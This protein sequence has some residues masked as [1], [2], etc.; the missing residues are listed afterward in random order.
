MARSADSRLSGVIVTYCPV[1]VL[2]RKGYRPPGLSGG[3][4]EG[5]VENLEISQ[6]L[7]RQ[8]AGRLRSFRTD[9]TMPLPLHSPRASIRQRVA[10]RLAACGE[11]RNH[12]LYSERKARLFAGVHG[13]VAELGPGTGVN[14][15]YLRDCQWTGLEPN[16]AMRARLHANAEALGVNADVRQG[17]TGTVELA[18]NSVDAVVSTLVLCSV[19]SP[20]AT[21]REVL[22]ILKPGG[23]FLFIEH[24][25]DE[26]LTIR[27][28]VQRALRFTPWTFLTD[29][30]RADR[31]IANVI[32]SAGFSAVQC[33]SFLLEGAGLAVSLTRPH[34][35]GRA[36]K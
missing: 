19:P 32:R 3:K 15:P 16:P 33:E 30:C 36:T 9:T 12:E 7:K 5:E 22:R 17:P 34:V 29:G 23:S 2:P 13:R 20:A 11:S 1:L 27:R 14:F 10:A 26:S 21:L 25:I 31:D 35:S 24:V 6:R 4:P 28:V 8:A 18:S